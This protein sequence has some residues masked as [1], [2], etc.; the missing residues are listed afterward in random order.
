MKSIIKYYILEGSNPIA[1]VP[2]G[3]KILSVSVIHSIIFLNVLQPVEYSKT[4]I[5]NFSVV[6]SGKEM[7][8]NEKMNYIG[9]VN[10]S[11][12]ITEYI[13]QNESI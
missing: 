5:L 11:E 9:S 12:I 6:Q 3:S 4:K 1:V 13:F 10:R 7:F 2:E 8:I